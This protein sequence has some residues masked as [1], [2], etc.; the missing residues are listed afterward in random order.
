MA[1]LNDIIIVIF[2]A[3]LLLYSWVIYDRHG[4][5]VP[6]FGYVVELSGT[7]AL[8][9]SF[10]FFSASLWMLIVFLKAKFRK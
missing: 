3:S 8:M 7:S 5:V 4:F 2:S 1:K 9:L 10:V 6:K